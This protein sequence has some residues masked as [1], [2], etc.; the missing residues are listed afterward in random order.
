VDGTKVA[1]ASAWPETMIRIMYACY[2][3]YGGSQSV[4]RFNVRVRRLDDEAKSIDTHATNNLRACMANQRAFLLYA[5]CSSAL[6]GEGR[7]HVDTHVAGARSSCFLGRA[8]C[9]RPMANASAAESAFVSARKPFR[10]PRSAFCLVCFNTVFRD[11][12]AGDDRD[13]RRAWHRPR[14]LRC[15]FSMTDFVV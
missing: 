1:C 6:D 2:A 15:L 3:C 4:A 5:Q 7:T 12:A 11:H 14:R 8:D 9:A 10:L 13:S